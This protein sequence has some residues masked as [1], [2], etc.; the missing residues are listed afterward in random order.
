ME[1]SDE[2]QILEFGHPPAKKRQVV[3][4][5]L[6]SYEGNR[7]HIDITEDNVGIELD[8]PDFNYI[9]N[10]YQFVSP[11]NLWNYFYAESSLDDE[12]IAQEEFKKVYGLFDS[13]SNKMSTIE[14]SVAQDHHEFDN[15]AEIIPHIGYQLALCAVWAKK[16]LERLSANNARVFYKAM[17]NIHCVYKKEYSQA[18]EAAGAPKDECSRF[19]FDQMCEKQ[20]W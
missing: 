1:I 20:Q 8:L 7:R 15:V 19:I 11:A 18:D 5:T 2:D 17:V 9:S 16:H 10:N 13:F 3:K 12:D 14:F 4:P 6:F